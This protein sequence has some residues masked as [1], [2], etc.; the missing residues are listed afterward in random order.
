VNRVLAAS[1]MLALAGCAGIP[2]NDMPPGPRPV[3]TYETEQSFAAAPSSWPGDNWW[4]RYGDAQLDAL[5]AEALEGAPSIAVAEARLRRAQ[6]ASAI[7]R[8]ATLPQASASAAISQQKQSYN[9]LTPRQFTPQDW[10]GYGRATLDFS[11]EL[12]FWGRNRA[13]LA[14]ATSEAEAARADAA[15]ARLTL[16]TAI[17][18]SYAELARLHAA[19]DTARAA[20]E[21]RTQTTGLF[22]TRRAN[23][24]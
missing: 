16:A 23:G 24:L 5:V 19:H 11:W 2:S 9:Y 21:V 22:R 1:C 10:H 6:A 8:A 12:D 4:T 3:A 20:L 13:A 7:S 14:A 15:Q 18:S 17:A